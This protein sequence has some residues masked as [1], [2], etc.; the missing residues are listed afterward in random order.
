MRGWQ[1]ASLQT[2]KSLCRMLDLCILVMSLCSDRIAGIL[3][4][5]RIY[6]NKVWILT[7]YFNRL[8]SLSSSSKNWLRLRTKTDH[9]HNGLDWRPTTLSVTTPREDTG[10]ERSWVCKQFVHVRRLHQDFLCLFPLHLSKFLYCNINRVQ[11]NKST[12]FNSF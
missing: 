12:T 5:N 3:F 2:K 8:R 10:E 1:S 11:F 6:D 4:W 7:I 9:C